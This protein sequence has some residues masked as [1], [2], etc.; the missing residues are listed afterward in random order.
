MIGAGAAARVV[1]GW[2]L[3]GLLSHLSARAVIRC[4]AKFCAR[5]SSTT[6]KRRS[7]HPAVV[8][9]RDQFSIRWYIIVHLVVDED[10]HIL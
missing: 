9:N 1:P 7:A 2:S 4:G 6:V 10:A 5:K 3:A 8:S